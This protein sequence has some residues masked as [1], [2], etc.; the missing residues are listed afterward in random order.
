MN[1]LFDTKADYEI[2]ESLDAMQSF[3]MIA[4]AGSGKTASLIGVL[5]YLKDIVGRQFR[6]D[7]KK[8]LCITYTN[9]AV[10]EIQSRLKW[11]ELYLVTTIH[12][13]LWGEIYRLTPNIKDAVK[14]YLIPAIITKKKED[15][16]GG[17]S[18]KAIAAR[19]KIVFLE[20]ELG[21]IDTV[22]RFEYNETRFSDYSQGLLGHDD[23][24][25]VTSYIISESKIVQK[26]LGQKYPYI[27]V[28]EAQDTFPC[29]VNAMNKVCSGE[30]L[31]LIGY[32][33][34]PMQQI[35]DDRAGTFM[36]PEGYRIITKEENFRCSKS[37]IRLLN[38]IRR[39]VQQKPAGKNAEIEGSVELKLIQAEKPLAQRGKYTEEQLNCVSEKF[40]S[41][42]GGWGWKDRDDIV[43]LF[44]VRQM[45]AR[46]QGFPK[47]QELFTGKFAS[48][49]AQDDYENGEHFLLKPFINSLCDLIAAYRKDDI[50]SLFMTLKYTSPTFDPQG[51]NAKKTLGEMKKL[52]FELMRELDQLWDKSTI[53][54]ILKYCYE[55]N[56]CRITEKLKENLTRS[57]RDEEYN[58]E[59][60][61]EDKGD[62]L[63]DAFFE[64]PSVE[65]PHFVEFI[66][67]NTPF[68]TQHGVKGEQ[69]SNVVVVFDDVEASWHKFSFTKT[70]IP[71]TS[72]QPTEKQYEK[73]IKLAYVCFS[74]AK[75]NLRIILF[76]QEPHEAK[77]ELIQNGL[78]SEEQIT[79][80]D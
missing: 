23:V 45:I 57:P 63:A 66:R 14:N 2:R 53:G 19:E 13:F 62:W 9:R 58:E 50:K 28:D 40:D 60:H 78:F 80:D 16:N 24:I 72:G 11:D 55:K 42:L 51:I 73:T 22:N 76:T 18:K 43:Q 37:V 12:S 31:P 52:I 4:G 79:I 27:F 7:S 10:N 75:V 29:V 47:L 59:E 49:R 64:M 26:I 15:D 36:G 46:R 44:L 69:Y 68:S 61:S 48:Q 74:R 35:Y 54:E 65:V 41:T 70:L 6:R 39:D 77:A 25:E 32:F 3:A 8:I 5:E 1:T 38:S 30:G 17:N 71:Q 33:G 20:S 56:L 34:D 67:E 21:K